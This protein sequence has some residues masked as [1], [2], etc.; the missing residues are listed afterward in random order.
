MRLVAMRKVAGNGREE[1]RQRRAAVIPLRS[2]AA[3][4]GE[5]A[6][7]LRPGAR[8]EI[9]RLVRE[10]LDYM[11]AMPS[12][13]QWALLPRLRRQGRTLAARAEK[14]GP[15]VFDDLRIM[16]SWADLTAL[17]GLAP[18]TARAFQTAAERFEAEWRPYSILLQGAAGRVTRHR[19][20][21][22]RRPNVVRD[23]VVARL[24]RIIETHRL[25]PKAPLLAKDRV[26]G[27]PYGVLFDVA[28]ALRDVLPCFPRSDAALFGAL[29]RAGARLRRIHKIPPP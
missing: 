9:A 24:C 20:H 5:I 7:H 2:L 26:N 28:K 29:D 17:V 19:E 25:D 8:R 10:V 23:V 12:V 27:K 13:E 11:A 22:G 1:K 14:S 18:E 3:A 16:C 6:R 15:R 4:W 21:R